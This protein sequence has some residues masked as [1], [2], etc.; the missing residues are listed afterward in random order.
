V[1]SDDL[2]IRSV[3]D[4]MEPVASVP[5]SQDQALPAGEQHQERRR[6]PTGPDP[7][8]GADEASN[9]GSG[10]AREFQKHRIDKLA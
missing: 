2:S 7:D 4:G 9:L 8:E 5:A 10:T 1:A 3:A 6:T